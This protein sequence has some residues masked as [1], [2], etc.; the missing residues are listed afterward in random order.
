MKTYLTSLSLLMLLLWGTTT[1]IAAQ[2]YAQ[3]K[4]TAFNFLKIGVTPRA[5]AMGGAQSMVTDDVSAAYWN[6]AALGELN[7]FQL[8]G[9]YVNWFD[10]IGYASGTL[11]IPLSRLAQPLGTLAVGFSSVTYGEQ[12]YRTEPTDEPDAN[13]FTPSHS[14]PT[15]SWGTLLPIVEEKTSIGLGGSF[16]TVF[17]SYGLDQIEDIDPDSKIMYDAGLMIRHHLESGASLRGGVAMLNNGSGDQLP[18]MIR[19][20]VGGYFLMDQ[21]VVGLDYVSSINDE[22]NSIHAGVEYNHYFSNFILRPRVGYDGHWG[23]LGFGAGFDFNLTGG[24][25]LS[26][27]ISYSLTFDDEKE[28]LDNPL[29]LGVTYHFRA[30]SLPKHKIERYPYP[31]L[32]NED[33]VLY[34]IALH[35]FSIGDHCGAIRYLNEMQETNRTLLEKCEVICLKK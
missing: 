25:N 35:Y 30:R 27:D 17:T 31:P 29:R 33:R 20:G 12:G 18:T 19:A 7:Q 5:M 13:P 34:E 15:I 26:L 4:T 9:N 24:G 16:K 6:P 23:G 8:V 32:S 1:P 21:L 11:A 10:G 28:G 22:Q 14:M 3:E 2:E